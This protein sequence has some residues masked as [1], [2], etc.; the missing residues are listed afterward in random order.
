VAR[1]FEVIMIIGRVE[2][3]KRIDSLYKS[4]SSE[5]LVVY[6]RRR[7][8]KTYLVREQAKGYKDAIFFHVTGKYKANLATQLSQFSQELS[9][10]YYR[11]AS[12]ARPANWEDAF[13]L[14]NAEIEREDKKTVLFLDELPWLCTTKSEL[15]E[16]IDHYWNHYW[17]HNNKVLLIVC[18]S[19]AAWMIKNIIHDKGGLHNRITGEIKLLPFSLSETKEYLVYR[20]LNLTSKQV[21]RLYMA[22]G[23]VPYYLN[24]I[25]KGRSADQS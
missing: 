6:G 11:G 22:I 8:G 21:I 10:T 17:S 7:V 12:L 24:Y 23:G 1:F 13:K 4:R 15:L 3:R 5:F 2:E 18:G 25:D 14:L 16:T 9:R 20:N 19:A